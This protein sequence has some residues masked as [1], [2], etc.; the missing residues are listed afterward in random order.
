M[1]IAFQGSK[2]LTHFQT[3]MMAGQE[4]LDI[5]G[6]SRTGRKNFYEVAN[7]TP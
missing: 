7:P 2:N 1:V 6:A 5:L 4:D 3:D